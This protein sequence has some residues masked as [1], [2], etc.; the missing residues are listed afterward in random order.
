MEEKVITSIDLVMDSLTYL[1]H[2]YASFKEDITITRTVNN[3]IEI[4][5]TDPDSLTVFHMPEISSVLNAIPGIRW[6]VRLKNER[7][8]IF[9]YQ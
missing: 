5:M 4:S 9:I 8:I 3:E 6:F 1:L 7:P 2:R